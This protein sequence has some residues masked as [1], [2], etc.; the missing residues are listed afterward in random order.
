MRPSCFSGPLRLSAVLL[1]ALAAAPAARALGDR[2]DRISKFE[3]RT[4]RH[5]CR[6]RAQQRGLAGSEREAFLSRCFFGRAG[7][8]DM[9]RAC[10]QQGAAKGLDKGAL[11]L[12]AR[13]CVKERS[14]HKKEEAP[15]K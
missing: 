9:R 11:E 4:I 2:S 1:C 8:H 13:D 7:R 3:A 10:L 6:D 14:G 12:F 15:G 5:S